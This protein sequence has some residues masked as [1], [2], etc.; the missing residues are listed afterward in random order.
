MPQSTATSPTIRIKE[1]CRCDFAE[2]GEKCEVHDKKGSKK[3]I[4]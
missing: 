1:D 4:E 3:I 2:A